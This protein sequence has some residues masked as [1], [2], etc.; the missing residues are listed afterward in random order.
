MNLRECFEAAVQ[1]APHAL[2]IVEGDVRWTYADLAQEV[3]VLA[4]GLWACGL[5]RG[6][7]VMTLLHN[8]HEQVLIF[9][10]CQWLGLVYVPLNARLSLN[11]IA[12]CIEDAEPELLVFDETCAETIRKLYTQGLLP[13]HV[14]TLGSVALGDFKTFAQLH[15]DTLPS[16]APVAVTDDAIA[17]MLYSSGVTGVPKGVPRSHSNEVSATI[18]HILHNQYQLGESTVALSAF[19]HTM[20]LRMLLAMTMLNGKLVIAPDDVPA[21]YA[22][23]IAD[24]QVSCL[25]AF[26]S[27]YHDLLTHLTSGSSVRKLAYAGDAM[28]TKLIA[29][30]HKYLSPAVFVNHFGST[31]IYTYTICSWLE[32]KAGCA[33]KAGINTEL[34]LI[35]PSNSAS[36]SPNEQVRSGEVGELIVRLTSPEAFRGYWNRPDLTSRAMRQG[37]YYTGDLARQD[38]DGDLWVV[39]R[40]DDMV[41]SSGE[42]VYPSEVEAI[43]RTHT[44]I[45]EVVVMGIPDI[46]TGKLLTAFVIPADPA[47][48]IESLEAFCVAH[49][50]L[51]AFKRPA[52]FVLLEQ[53]PRHAHKILRRELLRLV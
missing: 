10:A 46:R 51:A 22:T 36:I 2:A 30:Y 21:T 40:I 8:R 52:K 49:P 31:E 26:P 14:Y 3:R 39:G 35:S 7:R 53:M 6:E 16:I 27:I 32:R 42:K 9:W 1:R 4:Q 18:A 12:Y 25:Y 15:L 13:E 11:D 41:I 19:C 50:Q 44:G 33:G 17:V 47:L 43:L 23:L 28:S 34:R 24:E 38:D 20:G 29:H 5:Q 37:W 48:T 45:Q